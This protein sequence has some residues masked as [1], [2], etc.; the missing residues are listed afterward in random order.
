LRIGAFNIAQRRMAYGASAHFADVSA[1]RFGVAHP[2]LAHRALRIGM[3]RQHCAS[4]IAHQPHASSITPCASSIARRRR[5]SAL[6][7]VHQPRASRI[8]AS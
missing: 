3:S 2:I 4:R 5:A 8:S 1:P 7:I 6:R